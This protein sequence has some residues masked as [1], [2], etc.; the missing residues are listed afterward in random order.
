MYTSIRLYIIGCYWVFVIEHCIIYA[1]QVYSMIIR[2]EH[3]QP[4]AGQPT[5][6]A[7]MHSACIAAQWLLTAPKKCMLFYS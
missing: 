5:D 6:R 3:I 1:I 7:C 2:P 4:T